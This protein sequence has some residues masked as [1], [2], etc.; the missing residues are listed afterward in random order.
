MSLTT[1]ESVQKLQ[2]ALHDK[3]EKSPDFRF[4]ALYDKVYRKDVLMFAYA[5]SKANG[6]AAGVDDQTFEDIEAY[7]AEHWLDE[8]TQEL[9]SQKY[10]PL[11]VRRVYIPK[12]GGQQR[13]LGVPAIRDRVVMMAAVLV[14]DPIFEADLQ[15]EQ[16]A[17]RRGRSALDAVRHVHKLINTGHEEIVDADLA[18]YFD[19]LPHSEVL[20][21]VARRVVDGAMLRLIK[22]WLK[23][24]VEETDDR[25]RKHRNT[26]NRDEGRGTPQGSPISPLLSNLYMR[27][28]VLGWKKLGHE[29]RLGAYIVNYAD[30]LVI[31][32][33]G[34]AEE[35]LATMRIMMTKLKLTVNEAKTRVSKLPEEKFDFLGYTFGRCYSAK[36]GRAYLGTVPSRKRVIRI[37]QAISSE[38]G[39]NRTLLEHKAVVAKLNRMMNGWANYFCLGPVSKAYRAVDRHARKRLRQWLC[40]KHKVAGRATRKYPEATLHDVLGLICLSARTHSF[41]WAKP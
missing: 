13:P 4:Y 11:P 40:A 31:C 1:P 26:R 9:K 5:C 7:G 17:Y 6:G 34:R 14:L 24:P 36:T 20:K 28:F 33:R 39:H 16:Y 35:A 37:C 38:T 15:P 32:C 18:G 19:S 30:D 25:G 3:A 23:A 41:S 10:R 2:A 29:K 22:M 12:P 27:R 8:L 21:S